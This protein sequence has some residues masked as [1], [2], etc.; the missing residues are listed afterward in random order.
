MLPDDSKILW[1]MFMEDKKDED[2]KKHDEILY[3]PHGQV[4]FH[5]LLF[6]IYYFIK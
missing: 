6:C 5:Y 2:I 1:K 3:R 4:F